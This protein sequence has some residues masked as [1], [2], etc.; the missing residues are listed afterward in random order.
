MMSKKRNQYFDFLRGLAIIMVVGIHTFPGHEGFSS[1]KDELVV[2]VRQIIN[3][4]VPI[5]LAIS[6]YFVSQKQLLTKSDYISFYKRQISKL[7]IPALIWGIPWLLLAIY[8][9]E[10]I[11]ITILLWLCCG[12]SVLYFIALIIQCYLLLPI[13]KKHTPPLCKKYVFSNSCNNYNF[14]NDSR[15]VD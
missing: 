13:I 10:N 11:F 14:S 3:C 6:G 8:G 12:L 2:L 4:A 9:G 7:Y 5:F 15:Y 1:F